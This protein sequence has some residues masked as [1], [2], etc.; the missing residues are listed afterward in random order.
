M[1]FGALSKS[2]VKALAQVVAISG[3]SFMNTGEGSISPYH[4]SRIYNVSNPNLELV[5]SLSEKLVHYIYEHPNS[6]NS[7]LE[8]RF[9]RSIMTHLENSEERRVGKQW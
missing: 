9:G 1:S 2:A 3:G 5:D 8:E 7:E 6:S 4:L